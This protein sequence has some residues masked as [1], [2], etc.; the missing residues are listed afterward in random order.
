MFDWNYKY[1][2]ILKEY[3]D[4]IFRNKERIKMNKEREENMSK[5]K[6]SFEKYTE[7]W[8]A[9]PES[10][11]GEDFPSYGDERQPMSKLVKTGP[12]D[13]YGPIITPEEES[14]LKKFY[15]DNPLL[16]QENHLSFEQGSMEF[17]E[18]DAWIQTYS[19]R[20]FN[21]TNPVPGAIVIQDIAHSLSNIC[22]FTGHCSSFYSVAQHSVLVSYLCNQENALHGLLHDGSEAY[23]Q[24]IASPIKKTIEFAAYRAVETKLQHAIYKRF[25]LSI[26]EPPDV[27]KADLLLLAT[28]ARDLMAPLRL[29]WDLNIRPLP[30]K[31][32]PLPPLEAKKLFLERFAELTVSK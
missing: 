19:G 8:N 18:N 28:E 25:R 2:S 32:I 23:C 13:P 10:F 12:L 14:L 24:D 30:F 22:R 9:D 1:K 16:K 27:K 3:Y 6:E 20:R 17:N 5:I 4:P 11:G 21:P 7:R 29:D 26:E 31:I 15:L